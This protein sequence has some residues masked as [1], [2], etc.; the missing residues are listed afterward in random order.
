MTAL[1]RPS[2]KGES[3][4]FAKKVKISSR[5][6]RDSS[7]SLSGLNHV[8]SAEPPN[9]QERLSEGGRRRSIVLEIE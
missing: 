3:V 2:C 1:P 6:V 8:T 4:A 5:K 9:V 7:P